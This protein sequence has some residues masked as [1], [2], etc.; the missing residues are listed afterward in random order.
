MTLIDWTEGQAFTDEFGAEL[1]LPHQLYQTL[2]PCQ[3]TAENDLLVWGVAFFSDDTVVGVFNTL[4]TL[5]A[6]ASSPGPPCNKE[7]PNVIL[8]LPASIIYGGSI[9]LDWREIPD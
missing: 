8:D 6:A 5:G 9:L 3:F 2:L 7:M 4:L 1:S